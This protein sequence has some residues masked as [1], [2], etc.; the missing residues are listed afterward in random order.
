MRSR[1]AVSFH[2]EQVFQG[3]PPRGSATYKF[4]RKD[5]VSSARERVSR[6]RP[7]EC[8]GQCQDDCAEVTRSGRSARH[9]SGFRWHD[10]CLPENTSLNS[11]EVE[12][13][14][15]RLRFLNDVLHL[16]DPHLFEP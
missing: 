1:L 3:I 5:R 15:R 14:E 12:G 13:S 8:Q 6:L 9:D 7:R 10:F 16:T 2:I 4:S 11:V